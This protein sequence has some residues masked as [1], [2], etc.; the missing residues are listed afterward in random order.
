M[1][2]CGYCKS[3]ILFG[4]TRLGTQRFCDK[5][6]AQKGAALEA[7]R[8][9]PNEVVERTMMAITQAP[10]PKCGSL[11][12]IDVRTTYQVWSALYV[13]RWSSK[14]QICCRSCATRSSLGAI[15]FCLLLGWWGLPWGIVMTPTQLV[16]NLRAMRQGS[17]DSQSSPALRNFVMARLG[18]Q[19]AASQ[20]RT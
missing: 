12:S 3:T 7:A 19:M 16:R 20:S 15:A 5:K 10:C 9:L 18:A 2:T 4:G 1:A 13:T 8:H 11:G 17:T 6:C 14:T